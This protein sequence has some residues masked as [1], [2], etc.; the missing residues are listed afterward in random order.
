M[1]FPPGMWWSS[2]GSLVMP[3]YGGTRSLMGSRVVALLWV[4]LDPSPPWES[5]KAI[6]GK[7]SVDGLLANTGPFGAILVT[8]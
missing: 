7:G 4:F 1:I 6:Y 2:I 3:E 8:L 5:L